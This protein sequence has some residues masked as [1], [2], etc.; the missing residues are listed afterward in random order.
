[1]AAW[2]SP[3]CVLPL[4]LQKRMGPVKSKCV[5]AEMRK[6][7]RG[8]GRGERIEREREREKGGKEKEK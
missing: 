1:M 5:P 2:S 4:L 6:K 3:I 7:E 8:G